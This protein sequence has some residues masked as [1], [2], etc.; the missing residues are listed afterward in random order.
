[1][2]EFTSSKESSFFFFNPDITRFELDLG[3]LLY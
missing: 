2:R 1:M 3:L